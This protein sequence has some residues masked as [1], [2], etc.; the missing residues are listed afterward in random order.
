MFDKRN[1]SS[2]WLQQA[3]PYRVLKGYL[4]VDENEILHVYSWV[5]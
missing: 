4:L 3:D 2:F 5:F 1:K